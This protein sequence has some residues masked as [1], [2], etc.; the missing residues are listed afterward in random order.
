MD[1]VRDYLHLIKNEFD[2]GDEW[3]FFQQRWLLIKAI[4][5]PAGWLDKRGVFLPETEH[6]KIPDTVILHQGPREHGYDPLLREIL[7][8]LYPEAHQA[9][10]GDLLRPRQRPPSQGDS[11]MAEI[12]KELSAF[13]PATAGLVEVWGFEP[14]TF[15]LRTRRSTN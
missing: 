6:R 14:Q 10:R 15:S 9:P 1:I 3:A 13:D 11:F 8:G 7:S 12:L 2:A 4:T 5:Y